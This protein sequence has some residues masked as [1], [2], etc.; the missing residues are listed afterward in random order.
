MS[1]THQ[2]PCEGDVVASPR[3]NLNYGR[4]PSRGI[5]R[6]VSESGAALLVEDANGF[7]GW[8]NRDQYV[9]VDTKKL[10]DATLEEVVRTYIGNGGP[11]L[12]ADEYEERI[13]EILEEMTA[14]DLLRYLSNAI[15]W[16]V[17]VRDW[18]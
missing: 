8:V 18:R 16:S 5:V 1:H 9:V 17:A 4:G 13:D 2:L 7:T 12:P 6:R 14:A 15:D 10:G 3:R 11:Q